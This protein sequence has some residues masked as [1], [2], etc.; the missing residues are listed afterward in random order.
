MDASAAIAMMLIGLAGEA[1]IEETAAPIRD[2]LSGV[3]Y[4][5]L[6]V[7]LLIIIGG[8]GWS[9]HRAL[10]AG[11]DTEVQHPDEVGDEQQRPD[12]S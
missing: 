1:K 7:V 3:S 4:V 12:D 9:F 11:K 2:K 8:L 10:A 5:I 6:G